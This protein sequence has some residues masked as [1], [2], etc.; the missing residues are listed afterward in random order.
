MKKRSGRSAFVFLCAAPA[1]ILFI[2]FMIIPTINVFRMSLF[3]R[4]AYSPTEQFIGLDNF[5]TLMNHLVCKI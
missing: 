1:V 2:I 3:R 4:S 5:T